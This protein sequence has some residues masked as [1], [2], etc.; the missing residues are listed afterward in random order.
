MFKPYDLASLKIKTSNRRRVVEIISRPWHEES[1]KERIK[2]RMVPN[3][4]TTLDEVSVDELLPFQ[5]KKY[6][7]FAKVICSIGPFPEDMLRYD[8]AMIYDHTIDENK[9][10]GWPKNCEVL[11]YRL[12]DRKSQQWTIDRWK[13]FCCD[14]EPISTGRL[15]DG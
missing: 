13:S 8:S 11:I 3:Q 6:I 1:G 12:V 4:P 10:L 14:I 15:N 2:V 5:K 7:Q 9:E